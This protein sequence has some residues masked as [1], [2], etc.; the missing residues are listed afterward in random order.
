[1]QNTLKLS[2][3]HIQ[4]TLAYIHKKIDCVHQT[5]SKS[6]GNGT[7]CYAQN[8]HLPSLTWFLSTTWHGKNGSFS[9]TSMEWKPVDSITGISYC[10]ENVSCYQ[11]HCSRNYFTFLGKQCM[12]R[13]TT[14]AAKSLNFI[15]PVLWPST[16]QCWTPLITRFQDL[17]CSMSISCE[18][19]R[20]KKTSSYW[21]KSWKAVILHLSENV[22]F[23][24]FYVLTGS[25]ETL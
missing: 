20:L 2:P 4:T 16:I 22:L 7:V 1:M 25:A 18:S 17:Y 21:Q 24:W 9:L 23:L 13:S 11:T 19:T 14:A 12:Q 6:L 8:Q 15:A 5:R 3:G 10:L